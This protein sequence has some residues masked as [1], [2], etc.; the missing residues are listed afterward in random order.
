MRMIAMNSRCRAAE[1]SAEGIAPSLHL[2]AYSQLLPKQLMM[3]CG[4]P[5]AIIFLPGVCEAVARPLL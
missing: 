1:P 4:G 2:R 3:P 5:A